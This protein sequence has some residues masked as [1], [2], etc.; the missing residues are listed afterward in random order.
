MMVESQSLR[1]VRYFEWRIISSVGWTLFSLILLTVFATADVR[2]TNVKDNN[3]G[4][5]VV[6]S[7]DD[8]GEVGQ[9]GYI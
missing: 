1:P 2:A 6:R 3:N 8:R 7:V 4:A 9:K 5:F